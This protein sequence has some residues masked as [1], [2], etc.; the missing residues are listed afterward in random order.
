M[1][2]IVLILLVFL[3]INLLAAVTAIHVMPSSYIPGLDLELMLEIT[4]GSTELNTVNLQYRS[5]GEQTWQSLAMR[6]DEPGFWRAAIPRATYSTS[7]VEYRFEFELTNGSKEYLPGLE[8][9][10]EAYV[11]A[12]QASSGEKSSAF[13]LLNSEESITSDEDYILAVSYMAIADEVDPA[14]IK[15]FVADRDVSKLVQKSGST[16]L[17]REEK[18]SPGIRK[19]LVMAIADGKELFS[20]TWITEVL[21]GSKRISLP[22][23]LKGS[24]N[25]SANAYASSDEDV[26]FG[27]T[28][29]DFATWTDLNASYSI[30]NASTKLYLSSLES[31]NKQPV[32]RYTFGFQIP[33]FELFLGDYSPE[34]SEYTLNGMNI[35]GLHSKL[36]TRY[37]RL[38]LSHGESVRKTTVER[39]SV[40]NINAQGTFKQEAIGARIAIGREDGF[41]LGFSGTRHRDVIS[42]LDPE[43]YQYYDS[44]GDI[45][46]STKAQ[47]N[48]VFSVD[49]SLNVPDQQVLMGVE[50]ATS[51]LNKNTIPGVIS[52]DEFDDYNV[53]LDLS[54]QDFENLFVIN[55]NLEPFN[56][57]KANTAWKAYIRSYIMKNMI[58]VEYR[59]IGSAFHALG[60]PYHLNDSRVI[61][62]S[63]QIAIGRILFLGGTFNH[64]KDNLMEHA[65]ETNSYQSIQTQAIL[66]IPNLPYLKAS[67]NINDSENSQNG[68]IESD[69]YIPYS[70]NYSQYNFG[71][72][73]D[74][75]QIPYVPTQLELSMRSGKNF[76]EAGIQDLETVNDSKNSGFNFNLS[77]RFL[78]IP[79]KT[80]I[81]YSN[82]R[83][84]DDLTKDEYKNNRLFL[85]AEYSFLSEMLKPYLS[86]SNTS[87]SGDQDK[88]SYSTT[89]LGLQAYPIR[90]LSITTDL[91]FKVYSNDDDSSAEYNTTT[92]RL[93]ISQRF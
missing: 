32:N 80:Q 52:D 43:Y 24:V 51:L 66:R 54:P 71:I 44:Q 60:S 62:V 83:N 67:F 92:W 91:G 90:N 38:Y 75:F 8:S 85:R 19:A 63:D 82:A 7:E 41:T 78:P 2:K 9:S 74:F 45:Q 39:D 31:S 6:E 50:V 65:T 81:A 4:Q 3:L 26:S 1:K 11:I 37:L 59:E 69:A 5:S 88:Q 27:N 84:T 22:I 47:D 15:V 46:Y 61:S 36:D 87:L 34:F 58:T 42:S 77:S 16:L 86:Y 33:W 21:P 70:G 14:S 93:L 55:K 57:G 64:T 12:P 49:A 72:G 79:L 20:E 48:A 53:D 56:I 40:Q 76:R 25:L 29:S 18:P 17:Y 23:T 30:V 68:D 73:Y 13:V 28:L 35:R 10:H 89:S